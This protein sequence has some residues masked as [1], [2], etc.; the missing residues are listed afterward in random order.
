MFPPPSCSHTRAKCR[1]R[2]GST[3][4]QTAGVCLH[5]CLAT[6][7]SSWWGRGGCGSGGGGRPAGRNRALTAPAG[8]APVRLDRVG[9][10]WCR[11]GGGGCWLAERARVWGD[12]VYAAAAGR[13]VGWARGGGGRV[14]APSGATQ[15]TRSPLTAF[16]QP[17]HLPR[18]QAG[19]HRHTPQP[20]KHT[21]TRLA[22]CSLA[23]QGASQRVSQC[24][25][26]SLG[27]RAAQGVRRCR[28]HAAES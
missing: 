17:P 4:G 26:A 10:C 11:S 27:A 24:D 14:V 1:R 15:P 19:H 28:G 8:H 20:H 21:H 23:W 25:V 2:R 5:V 18:T 16:S 7:T 12:P 22:P 6:G 13:G 3:Q 9:G